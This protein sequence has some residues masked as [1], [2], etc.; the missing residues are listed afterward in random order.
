[1]KVE[2]L[3]NFP[4]PS[5]QKDLLAFLGALN[6]Y[7]ASLPR[8]KPE[9]SVDKKMPERS[10][11]AVLDPLYKL[12]TC[13]LKKQKGCIH[14]LLY[15]SNSNLVIQNSSFHEFILANKILSKNAQGFLL[16]IIFELE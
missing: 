10:P 6:Y 2:A 7:R 16:T 8:L 12:A 13:S 9:D 4:P 5:K 1:M 11:A 15:I 3:Q 14:L